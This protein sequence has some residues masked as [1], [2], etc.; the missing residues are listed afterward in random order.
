MISLHT[1][2]SSRYYWKEWDWTIVVPVLC[3]ALLMDKL[4]LGYLTWFGKMPVLKDVFMI[5]S[6]GLII[7]CLQSLRTLKLISSNPADVLG[8]NLIN[9]FE[10]CSSEISVHIFIKLTFRGSS[11]RYRVWFELTFT[12]ENKYLKF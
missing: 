8:L 1:T 12:I 11:T 5:Q 7:S 2:L 3:T 9:I 6:R 4:H 10:S